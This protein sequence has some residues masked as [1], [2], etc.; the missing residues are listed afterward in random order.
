MV[1]KSNM[2][3]IVNNED[4]DVILFEMLQSDETYADLKRSKN[5]NIVE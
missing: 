3:V 1:N 4:Y 5:I 2:T